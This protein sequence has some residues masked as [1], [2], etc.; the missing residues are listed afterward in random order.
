M[1]GLA[2]MDVEID[3]AGS[4]DE[5]LGVDFLDLARSGGQIRLAGDAAI[6]DEE[7]GN[8]IAAVGGVDDAS[9]TDDEG[10]V[11]HCEKDD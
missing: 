3:Q 1:T 10:G 8:F 4:D 9:V 11:W 6:D 7:V 2:E 5:A